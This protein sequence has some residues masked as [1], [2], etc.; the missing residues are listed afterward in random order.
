[1]LVDD[2]TVNVI[3]RAT[4]QHLGSHTIDPDRNYWPTTRKT[5]A[6]GQGPHRHESRDSSV[7]DHA[8]HD[9]V[10]L[11]GLEPLTPCLPGKCSTS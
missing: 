3:N 7:N 8:T 2:H 5:P 4:D 11:R 6:D 10:E 1:M 9:R